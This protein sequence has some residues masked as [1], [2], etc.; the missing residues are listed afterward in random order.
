FQFKDP[1]NGFYIHTSLTFL[2]DE[3][4]QFIKK[5]PMGE[6]F[7]KKDVFNKIMDEI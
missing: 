5:F 1:G 2:I 6:D 7:N 4:N 3:N